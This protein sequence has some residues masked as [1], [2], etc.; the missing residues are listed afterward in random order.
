MVSVKVVPKMNK[1][2]VNGEVPLYIRFIKDRKARFVSLGISIKPTFWDPVNQRLKKGHPNS[3]RANSF[4]SHRVNDARDRIL[5]AQDENL[6]VDLNALKKLVVGKDKC[7]FIE[8][9][10]MELKQLLDNK[11]IGFYKKCNVVL[12]KIKN[13]TSNQNLDFKQIDSNWLRD[14]S[15]FLR[16]TYG[17]NTNTINANLKFIRK[18]F[19]SAIAAGL[20]KKEL[21]PFDT[22]KLKSAKKKKIE[23]LKE[24]E[25]LKLVNVKLDRNSSE[26]L[27]RNM[28]V[29]SSYTGGIRISDLLHLKWKCFDGNKLVFLSAKTKTISS[30]KVPTI[31]KEILAIY[32]QGEWTSKS[33]EYIFPMLEVTDTKDETTLANAISRLTAKYNKALKRVALKAKLQNPK[34][35]SHWARRSFACMAL[36]KGISLDIVSKILGHSGES[37]TVDS[38]A[39]FSSSRLNKAMEVFN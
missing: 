29:F 6:Y 4:I 13:F 20:I 19:N 2:K 10:E 35:S 18:L 9:G 22:F 11:Q 31:S 30:I 15:D 21:Y 3:A 32:H 28:F 7:S 16:D 8:Y 5:R 24:D 14:F 34:I 17:N 39:A 26:D 25:I 23:H 33:N 27:V 38:Y 12:G 1:I 36:E 37:I